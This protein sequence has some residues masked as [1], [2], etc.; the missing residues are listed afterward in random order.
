MVGWSFTLRYLVG[1]IKLRQLTFLTERVCL[2]AVPSP[3]GPI[4]SAASS[5]TVLATV[6][7]G[8]SQLLIE[9]SSGSDYYYK[10]HFAGREFTFGVGNEEDVSSST[11]GGRK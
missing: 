9:A 11:T 8:I 10:A 7:S 1:S 3:S 4:V 6:S 5:I 2:M